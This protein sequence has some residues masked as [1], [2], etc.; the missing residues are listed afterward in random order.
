[1][2]LA[3][4]FVG[5]GATVLGATQGEPTEPDLHARDR[6]LLVAP[7]LVMLLAVLVLGVYLPGPLVDL[8]QE[9]AALLEVKL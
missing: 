2:L 6:L 4:V 3:A 8:L 9:G 5:M 1:L 7:P